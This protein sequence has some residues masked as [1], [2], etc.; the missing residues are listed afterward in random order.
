LCPGSIT[1]VLPARTPDDV[2]AFVVVDDGASTPSEVVDVGASVDDV[3]VDGR[4]AVWRPAP[5]LHAARATK[6]TAGTH[7]G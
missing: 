1:T 2:V 6:R 3:D 5:P 4:V 7:L